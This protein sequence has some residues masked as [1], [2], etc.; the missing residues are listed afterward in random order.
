VSTGRRKVNDEPTQHAERRHPAD[1]DQLARDAEK[2][3][4]YLGAYDHALRG[5]ADH[6][7]NLTLIYRA[8]LNL[9]R[10]GANDQAAAWYREYGL[11]TS[12]EERIAALGAR[13][14]RE[15]AFATSGPAAP[16]SLAEAAQCY[17][18]IHAR[19]GGTFTGINAATLHLLAGEGGP[20]RRLARKVLATCLSEGV[21]SYD[22]AADAAAAAL[23][24]GDVPAAQEFVATCAALHR[25]NF[26]AVASTRRQLARICDELTLDREIFA[27]LTP[28]SVMHYTG[29]LISPPNQPG[30]F[31]AAAEERVARDI[32]THLDGH[33]V[34][35]GFGS[36]ACGGDI[37]V[38][39]ALLARKAE[40]HVVLP[41]EIAEF[42]AHSVA[43]GGSGWVDRFDLCLE[44]ASSLTYATDDHY[45][46]DNVLFGHCN[47]LAMG[48]AMLR[49][50]NLDARVFQLAIWDG[51]GG[52][53]DAGTSAGVASWRSRGFSSE[54]IDSGA[55]P[56]RTRERKEPPARTVPKRVVKAM[57]FGDTTGFSR[58][59]EQQ[60][61]MFIEH[62][63]G[64]V[65]GVLDRYA[66]CIDYRN[67]WGDGLYLVM[68]D[69]RS[70]ME[71]ALE[72]QAEV[73]A[74]D[75]PAVGLPPHLGLR[76]GGHIG[77]VFDV[78][79]PILRAR[80]FMGGHVSRTARM[81]P[82]TPP[83]EVYV[84]EA[85][86]A[87]IALERDPSLSCEYVGVVP[88]A[89][90]YGSFRM[91]VLKRRRAM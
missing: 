81:E 46:G 15:A 12:E 84:T 6:P 72:L 66:D 23:I 71:C 48:L 74:I 3:G 19:T 32:A 86:A 24:I 49:A 56:T 40:L 69:A 20:A 16:K 87:L 1:W 85:F 47:E 62:F 80:N 26:S 82:V 67:T 51:A 83:G 65:S 30:R 31:P 43:C 27:K 18:R 4:D 25:S 36:L 9:S 39:E 38:A 77:P 64:R 42:R 89:K 37:L 79:D 41:F 60:I 13:I 35:F 61:P 90:G 59:R 57:L 29:H 54:I 8:V 11:E 10:S 78:I 34:G 88:A 70:A 2:S 73:G 68:R 55:T 76:V 14:M 33:D 75:Y 52:G 5:L 44:R 28:K 22:R 7:G 50:A 45:L 53:T 17:A 21:R 63:L 58:L 91:Y